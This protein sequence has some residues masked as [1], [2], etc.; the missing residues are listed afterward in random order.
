MGVVVRSDDGLVLVGRRYAEPG[1][2]LALPGGKPEAG[3]TIEQ[4]AVRELA[5]E[6]GLVLDVA[7]AST[8]TCVLMDGDE[9]SWAVAGVEASVGAGAAHV[10]PR[11]LEPDK[12][13]A[14]VWIDPAT[15]PEGLFA[16]TRA[17][18]ERLP[19]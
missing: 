18:L 3:E 6:T 19:T 5:E 14:F 7:G 15:P 1:A 13:G 17:L 8:F 9:E 11:E 2:P 4:C 12:F 16:A 10:K